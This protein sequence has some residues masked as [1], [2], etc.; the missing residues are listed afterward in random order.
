MHIEW[1]TFGCHEKSMKKKK[2]ETKEKKNEK[3]RTM[4]KITTLSRF[5]QHA[6]KI[7]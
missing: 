2:T 3:K 6:T 5:N 7:M 4:N 1:F